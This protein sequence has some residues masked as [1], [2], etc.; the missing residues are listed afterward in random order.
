MKNNYRILKNTLLHDGFFKL[1]ELTLKYKKH[2][3]DWSQKINREIFVGASVAA[4]LP[5]DH[6]KKKIILNTQFRAGVLQKKINPKLTEIVA[7]IIDKNETPRD[8]AIRECKEETG[9]AIKKVKKIVSFFP[10]P[11][12]SESYYH[13]YLGEV[14]SFKGFRITGQT[15]EDED[16]LAKCYSVNEIKEML[17][18]NTIINGLSLIALQWF[19]LNYKKF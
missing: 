10:S 4:V 6:V 1:K 14:K 13:L 11:G 7:G 18:N 2:N 16:I 12:A 3:G 5:Y 8:A 9:C 15:Q 19:L 17:N